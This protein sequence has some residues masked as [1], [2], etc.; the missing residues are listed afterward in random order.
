M[1][2][3]VFILVMVSLAFAQKAAPNKNRQVLLD[4]RVNRNVAPATIPAATQRYVLSKVFR[5]YLADENRCNAQFDASGDA[6]PL[7]AARKAG[8][9]VPSIFDS[10]K[11]S[12]T[13][14]GQSQTL[15]VISVSECNASHADNFGTKRVAIFAGQQLVA[16]F[17]VNFYQ[18]IVRKTDLNGDGIE[19]LLMTHGYTGQGTV[20]ESA[21]LLSFQ[22]GRL[23][24]IN[25]FEVVLEDSC[26]SGSQ[27]SSARASV[28]YMSDAVPAQM[29][30]F[31]R[32]NYVA[33]CRNPNRWRFVSSGKM[34]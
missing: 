33:T 16:E 9:I 25:D 26:A 13:A 29:P 5:R 28:L 30:K 24:V 2:P 7:A 32:D 20:T 12:F 18:S 27:G 8:Q 23:Q 15:Y 34:Q 31:T 1:K 14:A 10:A 6:D 22:N 4:F 21:A 11:G 17:D 19:E 3:L